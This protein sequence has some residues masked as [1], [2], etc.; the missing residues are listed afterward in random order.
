VG[1]GDNIFPDTW[2]TEKNGINISHLNKYYAQLTMFYWIWKNR[3]KKLNIDD[4]IGSCEH[5]FFWLDKL[6][7]KKQKFAPYSLYSKLLQPKNNIFKSQEIILPQPIVY[8]NRSLFEDFE[9]VHVKN[10]LKEVINFLP[11]EE[12]NPF[13]QHL[14]QNILYTGP[15]FIT[16]IKYFE[17]YCELIFPWIDQCY[18]YCK[19]INLCNGYNARLPA[20]LAERF[21]SYWV[22]KFKNKSILSCARLG[23]F[24]LSNKLNTIINT[25]KLPFTFYQYPTIYKY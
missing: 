25:T 7:T 8:K 4:F 1:L 24:H 6:Y 10:L 11:Q 2:E 9:E 16:K 15:L 12:Q 23:N 22:S 18:K 14:E 13:K 21:S 20:F 17:E 5:R 19:D 3:L